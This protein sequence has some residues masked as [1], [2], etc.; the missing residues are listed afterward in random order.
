M[1]LTELLC[2]WNTTLFKEVLYE[3][4]S[5]IQMIVV[6]YFFFAPVS[7]PANFPIADCSSEEENVKIKFAYQKLLLSCWGQ[8]NSELYF[9][10]KMF[11][12]LERARSSWAL[13]WADKQQGNL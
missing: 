11:P 7:S 8:V 6:S 1:N 5:I 12:D 2:K 4:Y 10:E 3:L 9:G 13:H